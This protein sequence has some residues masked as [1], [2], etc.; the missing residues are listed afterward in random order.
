MSWHYRSRHESLI[1]FSNHHYYGDR[2]CTFPAAK[3]TP[4]LGVAWHFV[5]NGVYDAKASRTNRAEAE[6]LVDYVFSRLADPSQKRR[7]AGVVTFSMAQ[8]NLIE[9]IFEERRAANPKYEDYFADDGEEPFFVKNLENVQGDERDVILFSVGYAKGPDGKFLM[10]L[11]RS[12]FRARRQLVPRI[13]GPSSSTPSAAESP[14]PQTLPKGGATASPTRSLRSFPSTASPS[15]AMSAVPASASMSASGIP[16]GRT[17]I[18]RR[19]SATAILTPL[20]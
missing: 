16:R 11:R 1:A 14:R 15:S 3:T 13:C 6:A 4:R 18:S 9:D 8:K 5:E 10:N 12:T 2:L 19:L 17:G 20:R 7:S